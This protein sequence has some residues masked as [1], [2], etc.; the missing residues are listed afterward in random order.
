MPLL[1]WFLNFKMKNIIFITLLFIQLSQAQ[2]FVLDTDKS[3][4][5]YSGSHPLHDWEGTSSDVKGIFIFEDEIP[6]RIAISTS[7]NSFNSK[8]SSRDAHSLEILDAIN[9]PKVT[10]YSD[11]ISLKE[12][13]VSYSGKLSLSG[14]SIDFRT[15]SEIIFDKGL[16]VLKGNFKV[17]P[18]DFGIKLP[19]FML[20]K[21]KDE[22]SLKY[23]LNFK[24]N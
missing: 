18:S 13:S 15:E 8:N 22:L 12:N 7:L 10:F 11:Q 6:S 4:I 14:V 17:N 1:Y 19:S 24:M 16:V 9:F 5:T 3:F 20:V 21:M 23:N 2:Q